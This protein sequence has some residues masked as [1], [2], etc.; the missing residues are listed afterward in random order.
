M[1][2]S[3]WGKREGGVEVRSGG[4]WQLT[5]LS[6]ILHPLLSSRPTHSHTSLLNHQPWCFFYKP[7]SA[8]GQVGRSAKKETICLQKQC[9]HRWPKPQN[10]CHMEE[11]SCWMSFGCIFLA[12][13]LSHQLSYCSKNSMFGIVHCRRRG[14][15]MVHHLPNF[16][17]TGPPA[18]NA[19]G[20]VGGGWWNVWRGVW[21]CQGRLTPGRPNLAKFPNTVVKSDKETHTHIHTG[22]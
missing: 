22:K 12:A 10:A 3:L 1:V 16:I 9:Q 17:Q 19:W 21:S 20:W 7:P 14:L 11:T 15:P 4:C 5:A 13:F 8:S 2:L 18:W 6:T